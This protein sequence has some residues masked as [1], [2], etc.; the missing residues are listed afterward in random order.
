M[1][2]KGYK[3]IEY[4]NLLFKH[5]YKVMDCFINCNLRCSDDYGVDKSDFCLFFNISLKDFDKI[6]NIVKDNNPSMYEEYT[7]IIRKQ[8][9]ICYR[10]NISKIT[11]MICNIE[12]GVRMDCGRIRPYDIIDYYKEVYLPFKSLLN[13][14]ETTGDI[15]GVGILRNFVHKYKRQITLDEN[16][17]LNVRLEFINSNTGSSVVLDEFE[18]FGIID[19]IKENNLPMYESIFYDG[20]LRYVNGYMNIDNYLNYVRNS[21]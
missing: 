9:E 15:N 18:K 10:D 17:I 4:E 8:E 3:K 1:G 16:L 13:I 19:Y 2:K 20:C 11:K 12:N 14:Y 7:N 6:I 21:K 5:V